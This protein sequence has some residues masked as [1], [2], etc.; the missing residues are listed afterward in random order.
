MTR[1]MLSARSSASEPRRAASTVGYRDHAPSSVDEEPRFIVAI[2]RNISIR[3][4]SAT[5]FRQLSE[6]VFRDPLVTDEPEMGL[7]TPEKYSSKHA[8]DCRRADNG[9][10]ADTHVPPAYRMCPAMTVQNS[11]CIELSDYADA[12]VSRGCRAIA[13]L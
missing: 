9:R 3:E 11:T 7:P 6:P 12:T 10:Q 5:V 8:E 1:R 4:R 2:N 13:V